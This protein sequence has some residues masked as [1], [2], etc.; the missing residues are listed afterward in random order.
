MNLNISQ[1]RTV[2]VKFP[3]FAQIAAN[4]IGHEFPIGKIVQVTDCYHTRKGMNY[5]HAQNEK[6]HTWRISDR[7]FEI[8]DPLGSEH[9]KEIEKFYPLP[10]QE[11]HA[12][13]KDGVRN[14]HKF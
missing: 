4:T 11:G 10:E 3:F 9:E 13:Y 1:E 6:Q 14:L 12:E 7:D 8:I 2:I 5:Y